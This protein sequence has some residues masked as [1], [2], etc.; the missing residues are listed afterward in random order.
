MFGVCVGSAGRELPEALEEHSLMDKGSLVLTL[1]M[2]SVSLT[3]LWFQQF[4]ISAR[5]E[6]AGSW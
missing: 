2:S 6:G 3:F 1:M 4:A 5:A